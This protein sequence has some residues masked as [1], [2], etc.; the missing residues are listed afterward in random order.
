MFVEP[1]DVVKFHF[2][3][4][5]V[6]LAHRTSYAHFGC[7]AH[8]EHMYFFFCGTTSIYMVVSCMYLETYVFGYVYRT[9]F[10]VLDEAYMTSIEL[11]VYALIAST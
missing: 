6:V 1:R 3:I 8:L 9:K 11:C 2:A 4:L 5:V 10:M 7:M